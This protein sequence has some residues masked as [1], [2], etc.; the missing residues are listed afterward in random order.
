MNGTDAGGVAVWTGSGSSLGAAEAR[1][2]SA[3]SLT[4]LL[5][6]ISAPV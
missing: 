4:M 1:A 5:A 3:S 6:L 2:I